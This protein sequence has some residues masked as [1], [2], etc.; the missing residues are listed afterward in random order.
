ML[1]GRIHSIE[2]FGASDG[3]GVRMVVFFQGCSLRCQYC[4]NPDTWSLAGGEQL[5]VED[6][7]SRFNENR[8]F[9]QDGGITAS[10]GEP[11]LQL[12]FLTELFAT[13]KAQHI[14]TC[15][16]TA[17]APFSPSRAAEY[18]PLANSLDL[19]LLDIKHATDAGHRAL[20][21]ASLSH[22]LAFAHWLEERHIP[23]RI[24]HVV[25]PNLTDSSDEL[26]ALAHL[27]RQFS[28]VEAVEVLGYHT[29]GKAKYARL[30]LPYPLG[31]TPDLSEE[32]LKH[33]RSILAAELTH[34]D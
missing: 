31:D 21:G 18:E 28:N 17:G 4:H 5:S 25:V 30:G 6:I 8:A 26:K 15:L 10:G 13:A 32:A 16:D 2:S 29:L 14:H 20:T 34:R 33:A 3:P 12:P 22:T 24:R 11:L 19:V 27:V 1:T 23:M 9:Y 7:L